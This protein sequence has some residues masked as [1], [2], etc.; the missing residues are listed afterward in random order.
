[1]KQYQKT[2]SAFTLTELLVTI[3]IIGILA[4]LLL[5]AISQ[6]KARAQRIQCANNLRQFGIAL[7]VFLTDNLGYP[8]WM[9]QLERNGLDISQPA[10]NF[11]EKDIWFCPSA[12][13]SA[14][15]PTN[16][17]HSYYGYNSYGVLR[18]GNDNPLGLR[19]N[20]SGT[21]YSPV[22][23]SEVVNPGDMMAMG[24]S[25]DSGI[26][27]MRSDLV[28]LK[29]YGNTLARHQG[30]ANVVFCDDHVESLTLQFLF[31][32]TSDEALSRWNRDHL[33]HREKLSP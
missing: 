7:H 20:Y 2:N 24:D 22:T 26:L 28:E 18:V 17:P 10:T 15:I 27:L 21:M 33:P 13:W 23:E 29:S 6:G 1:M 12:R 31:E 32:D 8:K 25:F 11:F 19:G 4:A 9:S 14:R 16:E 5:T 30:H 3:G